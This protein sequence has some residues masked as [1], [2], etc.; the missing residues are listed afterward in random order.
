MPEPSDFHFEVAA[1]EYD[2]GR[3]SGGA[4]A[5]AQSEA[6]G[7]EHRVRARYIAHRAR[8]LAE[9]EASLLAAQPPATLIY[10]PPAPISHS[11]ARARPW[12]W[13]WA[14]LAFAVI[15]GAG[16]F[17]ADLI[18]AAQAEERRRVE[19]AA[20]RVP[21]PVVVEV[22]CRLRPPS[23]STEPIA[24]LRSLT[25]DRVV[26]ATLRV[27]NNGYAGTTDVSVVLE[28]SREPRRTERR[29]TVYLQAGEERTLTFAF[30]EAVA[31][32]RRACQGYAGL[33]ADH[34]P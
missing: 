31:E 8:Q 29:E 9:R 28:Q 24:L 16:L 5:R 23:L 12:G 1:N 30:P 3:A 18:H 34:L 10:A 2:A 7:D 6:D 32:A 17:V 26:D 33:P 13:L 19:E 14:I 25:E 15:L 27:R 20:A 21:R 11:P 22:Q 4:L